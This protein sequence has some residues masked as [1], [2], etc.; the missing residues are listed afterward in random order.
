MQDNLSCM[1]RAKVEE[2]VGVMRTLRESL[3]PKIN[4]NSA[5]QEL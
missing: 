1:D 4:K 5:R 2:L 3:V